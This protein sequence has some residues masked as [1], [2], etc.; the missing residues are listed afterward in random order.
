MLGRSCSRHHPHRKKG[1]QQQLESGHISKYISWCHLMSIDEL[2]P[3]LD[4]RRFGIALSISYVKWQPHN[5][6]L[7]FF[8]HEKPEE[9]S[10]LMLRPA[11]TPCSKDN[12]ITNAT[13]LMTLCILNSGVGVN[14]KW[15][16][17][18]W[19]LMDL[20]R[21]HSFGSTTRTSSWSW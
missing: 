6:T 12:V 4:A 14:S 10:L 15:N 1:V 19:T 3:C 17:S 8:P 18:G 2:H 16:W 9:R 7:F 21:V 11:N 20:G 5:T 13:T